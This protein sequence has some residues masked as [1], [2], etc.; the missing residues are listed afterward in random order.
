M[1]TE[2][3]K[4]QFGRQPDR[5]V[6]QNSQN[7]SLISSKKCWFWPIFLPFTQKT[8]RGT[9]VHSGNALK[10]WAW[11]SQTDP[12]GSKTCTGALGGAR[13]S[14]PRWSRILVIEPDSR[15]AAMIFR[16]PPQCG[17]CSMSISN[18]RL[19]KRAQLIRTEAG[20]CGTSSFVS[21]TL[22]FF[23]LLP[24]IISERSFAFGAPATTLPP[25]MHSTRRA[26]SIKK[27]AHFG[28]CRTF[29]WASS[30]I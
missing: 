22:L 3:T 23:C 1:R 8:P 29:R 12:K 27:I 17:Q 26:F 13:E 4:E 18:T 28:R 10:R 15:M 24:G 9:S 19:S 6:I 2:C 16:V 25:A 21:D 20:G 30:G 14:K 11:F 7:L 5:K